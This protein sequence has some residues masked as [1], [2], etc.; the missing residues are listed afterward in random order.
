MSTR[1]QIATGNI[2]SD[3]EKHDERKRILK[4]TMSYASKKTREACLQY[5]GENREN[6]LLLEI[7]TPTEKR[8]YQIRNLTVM[9]PNGISFIIASLFEVEPYKSN[10]CL[11]FRICNEKI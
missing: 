6:R 4:K 9:E 1:Y 10:I 3:K 5:I 7:F 8:T 11:T 2:P